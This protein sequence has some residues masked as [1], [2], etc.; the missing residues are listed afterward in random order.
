MQE[1]VA[2]HVDRDQVAL[3]ADPDL[4]E[5][6]DRD[7]LNAPKGREIVPADQ[8]LGGFVHDLGIERFVELVAV[9]VERASTLALLAWAMRSAWACCCA[10]SSSSTVIPSAAAISSWSPP[11]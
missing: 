1:G 7:V 9:A 4:V 5:R 10:A 3:P 11:P 8:E 6:P 2:G